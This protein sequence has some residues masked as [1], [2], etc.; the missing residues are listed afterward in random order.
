MLTFPRKPRDQQKQ[1]L[2]RNVPV[3]ATNNNKTKN[4]VGCQ[5]KVV[6]VAPTNIGTR[7]QQQIK[8]RQ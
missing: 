3:W 1:H 8:H 6:G 5:L 7:S 4:V 2:E